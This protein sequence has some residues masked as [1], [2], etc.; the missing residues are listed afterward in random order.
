MKED[1]RG[2]IM[3]RLHFIHLRRKELQQEREGESKKGVQLS[4]SS[5]DPMNSGGQV[6]RNIIATWRNVQDLSA[7]VKTPY[8]RRFGELFS[9]P[10]MLF[11]ATSIFIRCQRKIRRGS[12]SSASM[13][14][15]G[16][17]LL[18]REAAGRE[19]CSLQ[20]LQ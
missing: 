8:Q 6:L 11:G 16:A 4:S 20:M 18:T 2:K 14:S 10:M 13:S 15:Q 17:V 19:T 9:G 5:P 3:V 1:L 12:I 7:D